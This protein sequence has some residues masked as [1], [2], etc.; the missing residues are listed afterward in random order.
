M[1]RDKSEQ[2]E[3]AFWEEYFALQKKYPMVFLTAWTPA[4]FVNIRHCGETDNKAIWNSKRWARVSEHLLRHHDA[5]IGCPWG[6]VQAAVEA[7]K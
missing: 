7:V 4:D 5:N 3:E 6:V 1:P 2:I